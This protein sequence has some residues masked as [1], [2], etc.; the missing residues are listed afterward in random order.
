MPG[1]PSA[2][3]LR[4]WYLDVVAEDGRVFIG[5]VVLVRWYLLPVHYYGYLYL[6]EHRHCHHFS[7][8]RRSSPPQIAENQLRWIAP[9]IHGKWTARQPGLRET[10]YKNAPDLIDWHAIMPT[11]S[12]EVQ[13]DPFGTLTGT[14][15]VEHIDMTIPP[16]K[17]PLTQLHWGRFLSQHDSIV[18]IRW[19]STTDPK[20]L[21]FHNGKRYDNAVIENDQLHFGPF[22]LR[23]TDST[24]LRSGSLGTTVLAKSGWMKYLLPRSILSIRETKWRSQGI[25]Q[26]ESSVS[27]Q[28]WAIHEIVD[29]S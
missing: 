20:T 11:A 1:M 10:L 23:L 13:L 5:Y 27:S 28:G 6:D 21:V 12:A 29:W 9:A 3:R 14:G 22:Q 19:V 24:E 2:F 25:L 26:S 8:Y 4:K 7:S 16:W 15:Y 18:W 17:L